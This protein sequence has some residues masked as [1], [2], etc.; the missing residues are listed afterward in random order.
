MHY[1]V[2]IESPVPHRHVHNT[3]WRCINPASN[4]TQIK[5][6]R[7]VFWQRLQRWDTWSQSWKVRPGVRAE[8]ENATW[9]IIYIFN[10]SSA[11]S[12]HFSDVSTLFTSMDALSDKSCFWVS[13][14]AGILKDIKQ[15]VFI[16][17]VQA[18]FF[19]KK[20]VCHIGFEGVPSQ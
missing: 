6:R 17:G 1:N 4:I 11:I 3:H 15:I 7:G 14:I 12:G 2:T 10:F 20:W 8:I 5:N 16:Q 9:C 19:G 13:C 18:A